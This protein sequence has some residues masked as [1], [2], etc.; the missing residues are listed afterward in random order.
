[1]ACIMQGVNG[2]ACGN[3]APDSAR[4]GVGEV[5]E[6]HFQ[7]NMAIIQRACPGL[8]ADLVKDYARIEVLMRNNALVVQYLKL[9]DGEMTKLSSMLNDI[10]DFQK[11]A[12]EEQQQGTAKMKSVGS[13]GSVSRY[14]TIELL[15]D[16]E[17]MRLSRLLEHFEAKCWFPSTHLLPIGILDADGFFWLIENG[18]MVKD[19]GAGVEHGE[20]THRLQWHCISRAITRHFTD[21]NP[22]SNGWHHSPL[23]LYTKL[24]S[25]QARLPVEGNDMDFCPQQSTL[26]GYLFDAASKAEYVNR[27]DKFHEVARQELKGTQLGISIASRHSKRKDALNKKIDEEIAIAKTSSGALNPAAIQKNAMEKAAA[28][29]SHRK[30]QL[31]GGRYTADDPQLVGG[32]AILKLTGDTLVTAADLEGRRGRSRG[33]FQSVNLSKSWTRGDV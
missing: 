13:G 21:P 25:A 29:Y 20:F 6:T 30:H 22:G 33:S 26:W 7:R 2:I 1:M 18:Y 17:Y 24:G 27:P 14:H 23:E 5:C 8:S 11:E 32:G 31:N 15:S 3:A 28:E 16:R 10:I 4:W 12:Y 9:L 19:Y